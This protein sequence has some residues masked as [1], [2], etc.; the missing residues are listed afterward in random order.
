MR[1][2]LYVFVFLIVYGSLYPFGFHLDSYND[3]QLAGLLSFAIGDSGFG[4]TVANILLFL[5]FGFLAYRSYDADLKPARIIWILLLGFALAYGVQVAQVIIPGRSPSGADSIWNMLGCLGGFAVAKLPI[6]RFLPKTSGTQSLMPIP[7]ILSLMWLLYNWTPFVPTLDPGL[8][9][10]NLKPLLNFEIRLWWLFQ[11]VVMWLVIFHFLFETQTKLGRE[12]LF[13]VL[14]LVVLAG[15]LF[16]VGHGLSAE[17]VFGGLFALPAWYVFRNRNR[18][19]ILAALLG[20]AILATTFT[21]FELRDYARP[22][23]WVPFSGA[24]SSNLLLNTM[25]TFKKLAVYGSFIWL[26]VEARFSLRIATVVVAGILLGSELLQVFFQG[27]T[28][29]ITDPL[30]AIAIGIGFYVYEGAR[31]SQLELAITAHSDVVGG[32]PPPIESSEIETLAAA[33]PAVF[34]ESLKLNLHAYQ[35][36][37]LDSVQARL[38]IAP[39]VLCDELIALEMGRK[40]FDDAVLARYKA[41]DVGFFNVRKRSGRWSRYQL[42]LTSTGLSDL[43]ALAS[44]TGES[45]S[46]TL[47]HLLDR[48]I[49]VLAEDVKPAKIAAALF[50]IAV[51]FISK[52]SRLFVAM[53]LALL[54]IPVFSLLTEDSPTLVTSPDW[55][56]RKATII[57]D[58]HSHTKF[59]DGLLTPTELVESAIG[60]GCDALAITDHSDAGGAAGTR[61]L[62]E[63]ATLRASH[64]D[65][66]LLTG[67][68]LN[69]PSYGGRE[70]VNLIVVPSQESRLL[71][72]LGDLAESTSQDAA[73]DSKLLDA[74]NTYRK[75]GVPMLMFY[76]HPSR[77][78]S[79]VD[80]SLQDLLNWDPQGQ[81]FTAL[82]GSPGHQNAKVIGSY[83]EPALTKDRWDPV[84]AKTGGVWDQL[85]ARGYNLWGALASSDY[86][87]NNLDKTPC[88]FSRIHVAA[89]EYSYSGLIQGIQ[90]GTFWADHGRLLD[91]LR[92]SLE[93]EGL[94]TPAHPGTVVQ[95]AAASATAVANISLQ[96]GPGSKHSP[97]TVEIISNCSSGRTQTVHEAVLGPIGSIDTSIL[98][99]SNDANDS[100]SC[101]VRA[102]VRLYNPLEP[103][104]LAYT[105]PIRILF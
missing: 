90:A 26:L 3:R 101:F 79:S 2:L 85:F 58:G 67:I 29:E 89:P 43:E 8:I 48:H 32:G 54:L 104:L 31:Q 55:A 24:L 86:H 73:G 13:P 92:F 61:Q 14:V 69:M 84:A 20:L 41:T 81:I 46:Y 56:G 9:Y 76:N 87:N 39:E 96:R 45:T 15:S 27:P 36:S 23:K 11:K 75:Q 60:G 1:A 7:L 19:P 97:L 49:K 21:P 95:L 100:G 25:A 102:R 51:E 30:L 28:P 64:P 63:I 34:T 5:P 18:P 44:R 65:F 103:D 33:P 82:A 17:H 93:F 70:H 68:E 59:S 22:F 37:F 71:R 6:S 74:I 40:R 10:D 38:G 98:Y 91:S 80:E 35:V 42:S 99:M 16:I 77:K 105:N 72:T 94:N 83:R 66:L 57:F 53:A 4:D 88:S 62:Q 50:D 47:R 52:H 78:A 12:K